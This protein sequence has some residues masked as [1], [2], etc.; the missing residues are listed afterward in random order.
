MDGDP[1]GK[2]IL[3]RLGIDRFV[4]NDG[5]DYGFIDSMKSSLLDKR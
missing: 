1:K 2:D 5:G 3:S 4:E